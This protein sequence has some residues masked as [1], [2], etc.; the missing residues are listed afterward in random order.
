MSNKMENVLKQKKKQE[1]YTTL[2]SNSVY[3]G[4]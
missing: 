3:K 2:S 1:I 4:Y